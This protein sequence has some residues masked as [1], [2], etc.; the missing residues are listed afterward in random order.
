M[1]FTYQHM[2]RC[3]KW[4]CNQKCI[5]MSL[6][7]CWQ[8]SSQSRYNIICSWGCMHDQRI[9][10]ESECT[11]SVD[12]NEV[13][14]QSLVGLYKDVGC[15]AL[16]EFGVERACTQ[17]AQA[18]CISI[19]FS[20]S[21]GWMLHPAW[22]YSCHMDGLG[23]PLASAYRDSIC[24]DD[25]SVLTDEGTCPYGRLTAHTPAALWP[26]VEDFQRKLDALCDLPV[27]LA[28]LRVAAWSTLRH[29]LQPVTD[30]LE[31]ACQ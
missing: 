16:F 3:G 10:V 17:A 13:E 22:S 11:A 25:A 31:R 23:K 15:I 29:Q 9:C 20:N 19:L 14:C 7:A 30:C 4:Q 12:L 2:S 21:A 28:C 26:S 8:V 1:T 18:P 24:D 6:S 5:S 27:Q